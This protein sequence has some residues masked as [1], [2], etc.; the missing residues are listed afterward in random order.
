MSGNCWQQTEF[1]ADNPA[2]IGEAFATDLLGAP[3]LLKQHLRS[4]RQDCSLVSQ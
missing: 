4:S 3:T 1:A 2:M